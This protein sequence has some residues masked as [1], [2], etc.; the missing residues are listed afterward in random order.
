MKQSSITNN[1]LIFFGIII[2]VILIFTI[3]D[4]FFQY[5]DDKGVLS[6]FL[7]TAKYSEAKNLISAE[8]ARNIIRQKSNVAI[9]AIKF[10]N[11]TLLEKLI[12]PKYGVRF[13]PFAYVMSSDIVFSAKNFESRYNGDYVYDWGSKR[14]SKNMRMTFKDYYSSYIYQNDYAISQD[15]SYND[16]YQIDNIVDNTYNFYPESIVV[17]YNS[18]NLGDYSSSLLRLVFEKY[19]NEYF[20]S[21]IITINNKIL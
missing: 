14:M 4:K 8:N 5:E 10:R 20:L 21:G 13:S 18:D 17:E 7:R 1:N 12:H 16:I 3:N 19:K 9:K 11:F 2:S 6:E 15:I